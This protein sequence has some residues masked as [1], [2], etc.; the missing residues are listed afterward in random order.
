[1]SIQP[2]FVDIE[3]SGQSPALEV[4]VG[5]SWGGDATKEMSRGDI[6]AFKDAVLSAF[7]AA[8][9]ADPPLVSAI[10]E[11]SHPLGGRLRYRGNRSSDTVQGLLDA[12]V[13]AVSLRVQPLRP[14]TAILI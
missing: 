3:V 12:A 2:A 5:F 13:E 7:K 4:R 14:C 8:L 1:M 11:D 10:A 6:A 9:E